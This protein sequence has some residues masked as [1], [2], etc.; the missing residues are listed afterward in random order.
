MKNFDRLRIEYAVQ[1]YDFSLELRGV[2]GARRRELRRELRAN[3]TEASADVGVT[4][5]LFGIGSPKQLAY[6]ATE[7]DAS[8]PRWSLG[9]FWASGTFAVLLVWL[10]L[11]MLTIVET[12]EA[13]G[14]GEP[15]SVRPFPWLGTTFVV[16]SSPGSLGAELH[17]PWQLLVGPLLVFLLVAQPWRR[18]RRPQP[19]PVV[20]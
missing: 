17:A 15:V 13:A 8:R 3:L 4:R 1:R 2:S 19:L 9:A 16:E 12:V 6:A 5:A 10:A 18:L 11:T 20:E 14:V 7:G